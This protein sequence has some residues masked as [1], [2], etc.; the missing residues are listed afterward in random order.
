M[1]RKGRLD[2]AEKHLLDAE[3]EGF[4]FTQVL[5]NNEDLQA[6]ANRPRLAHLFSHQAPPRRKLRLSTTPFPLD[7]SGKIV[8]DKKR[9]PPAMTGISF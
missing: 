5:K 8:P 9:T 4:M 1:A 2:E 6:L 3:W 7:Y